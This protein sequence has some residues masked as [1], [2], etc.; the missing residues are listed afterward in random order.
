MSRVSRPRGSA[1]SAM[2]QIASKL[3]LSD[4]SIVKL[5]RQGIAWLVLLMVLLLA[6][7]LTRYSLLH[8]L[9]TWAILGSAVGLFVVSYRFRQRHEAAEP[10]IDHPLDSEP[11]EDE[12]RP[13]PTLDNPALPS[14]ADRLDR[15][16]Y[17]ELLSALKLAYDAGRQQTATNVSEDD[18]VYWDE[19]PYFKYFLKRMWRIVLAWILTGILAYLL[20]TLSNVSIML[21]LVGISTL[22]ACSY[23]YTLRRI[24][25]WRNLRLRVKGNWVYI[26]EPRHRLLLLNGRTQ[27][28]P[29]VKCDNAKFWQ[30]KFEL[31][32]HLDCGRVDINTPIDKED[33]F[34]DLKDVRRHEEFCELVTKRHDQLILDTGGGR[35]QSV[36]GSTTN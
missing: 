14:F 20:V 29:L 6:A 3:N 30:T 32:L 25:K 22:V 24:Y 36:L 1:D 9:L 17:E 4:E 16:Q 18:T 15:S 35:L 10:A 19:N 2:S 34:R 28:V 11:D 12:T 8:A 27:K 23:W 31:E 33:W 26:E 5:L 21:Q 13:L 7:V